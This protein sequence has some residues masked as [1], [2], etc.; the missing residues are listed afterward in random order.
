MTNL[1]KNEKLNNA[2]SI[3]KCVFLSIFTVYL[4]TREITA[5]NYFIDSLFVT[6]FFFGMATLFIGYDLLTNRYCL[7]TRYLPVALIFLVITAASCII[8][9]EYGIFSNIKGLAAIIIYLFLLYPE[10]FKSK[11]ESTFTAISYTYFFTLSFYTTA[12]MPMFI[13]NVYYYTSENRWQGFISGEHGRLWGLYQD[14]N[15]LALFCITAM[16]LSVLMFIKT[17]SIVLKI[18]LIILDL[19]HLL[20]L[21]LSGS[22]MGIICLAFAAFW[23]SL[24]FSFKKLKLKLI[25]R[26]LIFV[27]SATLSVTLPFGAIS[28][29]NNGLPLVK[30]AILNTGNVETYMDI[31]KAYNKLYELG[32]VE[33]YLKSSDSIEAEKYPFTDSLKPV[34]RFENKDYSNDGRIARWKDGLK[35]F[36]QKPFFG[37][38]P[39]NIF[40]FAKQNDTETLMGDKDYNIHNTYLEILAGVGLIGGVFVLGFLLL[41]AVFVFKAALKFEPNTKTIICTTI[42]AITAISA[43]LLPDII[44]FQIT[45]AGLMFWLCLGNC[46]NIDPQSYK[47]AFAYKTVQKCLKKGN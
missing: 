43:I 26:I 46:L 11:N 29:I 7:K 20:A 15:Y 39:R 36:A 34:D 10:A 2:V 42:I 8:N 12:S 40:S 30:K 47:Q 28:G 17:K 38:S 41:A 37:L 14:P 35:L 9:R 5:L 45:A 44:F 31:H 13:Y 1:I 32:H 23:L 4:I 16:L 6:G 19:L 3:S 21:A 24:I 27:I 18:V 33:M 25:Y 22:R